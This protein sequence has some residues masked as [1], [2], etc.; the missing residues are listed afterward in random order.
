MLTPTRRWFIGSV[1]SG[2]AAAVSWPWKRMPVEAECEPESEWVEWP[3]HSGLWECRDENGKT[4]LVR[5]WFAG[6]SIAGYSPAGY[7]P[8]GVTPIVPP[9]LDP[10]WIRWRPCPTQTQRRL[11]D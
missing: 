2:I 10:E 6:R 9:R 7:S 8:A 3:T 4:Y 5:V 1:L 11:E